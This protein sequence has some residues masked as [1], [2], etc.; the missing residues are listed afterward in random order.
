[1][2]NK[3]RMQVHLDYG[4][5]CYLAVTSSPPRGGTLTL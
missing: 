5:P 1:M 2:Y 4:G 3:Y